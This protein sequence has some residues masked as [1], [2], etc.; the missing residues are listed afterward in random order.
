MNHVR[1]IFC[2]IINDEAEAYG[3]R[4][5]RNMYHKTVGEALNIFKEQCKYGLI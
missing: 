1:D 2:S 5:Y 3:F 4:H